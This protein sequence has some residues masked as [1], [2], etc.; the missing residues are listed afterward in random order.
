M[1]L[2][3]SAYAQASSAAQ[4]GEPSTIMNLLPLVLI[5]AVFYIFLIRPQQ[6]KL[7]EHNDMVGSI[8]RGDE[9]V[10]GGGIIGRVTK[11]DEKSPIA[12]VEISDGVIVRINKATIIETVKSGEVSAPVA[13]NSSAEEAA[14]E[15]G[16]PA[17][18]NNSKKK[19]VK[20]AKQVK[21]KQKKKAA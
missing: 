10:T 4:T 14:E 19:Q 13:A 1:S 15:A 2:I 16:K 11:I 7:K 20:A 6:K 17:T 3:S 18:K 5:F 21:A 12:F 9:V 8:K